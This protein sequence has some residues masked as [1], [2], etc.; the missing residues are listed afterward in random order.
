[1]IRTTTNRAPATPDDDPEDDSHYFTPAKAK[2]HGAVHFCDRM[3]VD[4]L[5]EDIFRTFN[6]GSRE[7]WRYLSNRNSSRRVQNDPVADHRGPQP[8]IR[9]EK[10]RE[11]ELV[12]ETEGIEAR[13]YTREQLG[14]EVGLEC[15]GRIVQRAIGAMN[16]HKC[17]ASRRG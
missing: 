13:A 8:L 16:Y 4:Y 11:M 17:I 7:G 3:E 1:M 15:T 5:K 2:V 9:P 10:I 12:L 6:V 14:F